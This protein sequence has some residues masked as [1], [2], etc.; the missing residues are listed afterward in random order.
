MTVAMSHRERRI[1][2]KFVDISARLFWVAG[3]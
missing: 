1:G 2:Y 3:R